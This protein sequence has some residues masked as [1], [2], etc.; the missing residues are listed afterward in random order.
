MVEALTSGDAK[1][2]ATT[3]YVIPFNRDSFVEN[4]DH[5]PSLAQEKCYDR[6]QKA[7]L[8]DVSEGNISDFFENSQN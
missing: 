4:T 1:F 2:K 7:F 5:L 8:S 3:R 6:F